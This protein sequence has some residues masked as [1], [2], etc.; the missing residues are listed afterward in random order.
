MAQEIVSSLLLKLADVVFKEAILLYG[1]NDKVESI[2]RE[3]ISIKAFLKDADSK[4]KGDSLVQ[5]WVKDVREVSF[6]IEDVIDTFLLKVESSKKPGICNT[7]KRVGKKPMKLVAMHNLDSAIN[8]IQARLKEIQAVKERYGIKSLEDS[9]IGIARLPDRPPVIPEIDEIN[10]VGFDTEKNKIIELLL[11]EKTSRRSVVS[12][13]GIGG[14]GKTTLAEK[15][16]QSVS[17]KQHFDFCV[18]LTVSKEFN[19]IDLLKKILKKAGVTNFEK[20]CDEEYYITEVNK[21]LTEKRYFIVLDDIWSKNVWTRIKGALPDH[22][23]GSRILITTRFSDIAKAANPE[24][25]LVELP[26]LN[27]E[28][29]LKLL[30][31]KALPGE[32]FNDGYPHE[33]LEVAKSFA[34]Q[35]GGLPLA[36]IVVGGLLSTKD[37]TGSAWDKVMRTMDWQT[38]GNEC[39]EILASSYED[40]PVHLKTCF[41][42]LASFPDDSRYPAGLLIRLWVGEGFIPHDARGTMEEIAEK[43]LEELAQRCMIQI[44]EKSITDGSIT[45]FRVHDLLHDLAIQEAK[46]KSFLKVFSTRADF[47]NNTDARRATFQLEDSSWEKA[48]FEKN[49][50]IGY[51]KPNV[52]TLIFFGKMIPFGPQFKLLRVLMVENFDFDDEQQ[53]SLKKSLKGLLHLRCLVL[54]NCYFHDFYLPTDNLHNL[55]TLDLQGS[56][57]IVVPMSL[58]GIKTLRHVGSTKIEIGQDPDDLSYLQS[59]IG[60]GLAPTDLPYLQ[61]LDWLKIWNSAGLE[62]L[63]MPCLGMLSLDNGTDSWESIVTLLAKLGCL[64]SLQII[65]RSDLPLG[66]IDTRSFPSYNLLRTLSLD[67]KWRLEGVTL[68]V[69]MFPPYLTE[70]KLWRSGIDQDPMPIL[71][72]LQCLKV[73][74]LWFFAYTGTQMICS[75]GGFP[76]LQKLR[77]DVLHEL[78]EWKIEEGAMPMLNHLTID[79]CR[80]LKMLPDLR[81]VPTLSV[82]KLYAMPDEFKRRVKNEDQ[83][84]IEHIPSITIR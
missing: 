28:E 72:K 68:N 74:E 48:S 15:V 9:S 38:D 42:Y 10:L 22:S 61:T 82:L 7:L 52:R 60:R 75:R 12:L 66:I 70:L 83:H 25:V 3:L 78:E 23:K 71:E 13:V 49:K 79:E 8:K 76:Q 24:S 54:R 1:V 44:L 77:L 53:A 69:D 31:K 33:L 29:S 5:I 40:L 16:Y 51:I 47:E 84:K 4:R 41:M 27:E 39:T 80:R 17:N 18:W 62:L 43:Y 36:L 35:C 58:L 2:E 65:G 63:N 45:Q 73:L 64:V 46:Q 6:L 32:T 56:F 21:F 37:R 57:G 19:P 20:D 50:L 30:F 67:G 34:K 59:L 55:Q 14:L 81:H 11:D 26:F